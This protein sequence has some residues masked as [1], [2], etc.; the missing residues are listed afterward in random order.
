MSK[1]LIIICS[2]AYLSL[3]FLIAYMVEQQRK[4][5][6]KFL[7]KSWIYA[8]SLAVYC[9]AWTFYGSVGRA[10]TNGPEFLTIYLGP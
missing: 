4:S 1:L 9:T 2:V 7:D 5:K 8:L 10:V 6:S 3:L